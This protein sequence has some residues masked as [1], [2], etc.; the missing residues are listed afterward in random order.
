MNPGV[1][2]ATITI[3]SSWFM[4][5]PSDEE[6]I[7]GEISARLAA[8]EI[9]PEIEVEYQHDDTREHLVTAQA[10]RAHDDF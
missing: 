10:E 1:Y 9:E 4:S 5:D 6:A 2:E 3:K 8:G 7:L